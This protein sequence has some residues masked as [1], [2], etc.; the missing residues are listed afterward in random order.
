MGCFTVDNNKDVDKKILR[1]L[2]VIRATFEKNFSTN[3]LGLFLVGGLGRGEGGV[4]HDD[5]GKIIIVNDYDLHLLTRRSISKKAIDQVCNEL[6]SEIDVKAID[7]FV[8][9][10]FNPLIL[11]NT[12]YAYD[13]KY[14]YLISGDSCYQERI[15]GNRI[16]KSEVE[17]LLFT[18]SWCFLGPIKPCFFT[19]RNITREERF[20]VFQQLSKAL[21]ALEEAWLIY[22]NDYCSR[23]LE[24]FERINKYCTDSFT[25]DYFKWATDFKLKPTLNVNES[26]PFQQCYFEIKTIFFSQ[27]LKIIN[28]VYNKK[29]DSWDKYASWYINRFDVLAKLGASLFL[30][31]DFSYKDLIRQNISR[32][33]LAV[34]FTHNGY[35]KSLIAKV[36]NLY[37]QYTLNPKRDEKS[38]WWALRNYLIDYRETY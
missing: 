35:D 12:Q 6:V 27:M 36:N 28:A 20:F 25:L 16:K 18:R 21:L 1:D 17:T 31:R 8:Q 30:N 37:P 9:H 11:Y 29:F 5:S 22:Q 33:M 38:R 23:Y 34:A 10:I 24:K 4:L 19:N 3:M 32:V 13:L 15:G 14:S 2:E 7:V 26:M